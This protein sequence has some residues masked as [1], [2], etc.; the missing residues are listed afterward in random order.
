[1]SVWHSRIVDQDY[2]ATGHPAVAAVAPVTPLQMP[3]QVVNYAGNDVLYGTTVPL[4][5]A[6][7]AV[8]PAPETWYPSPVPAGRA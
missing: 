2:L 8:V 7:G 5:T 1:M 6:D 3:V 4:T